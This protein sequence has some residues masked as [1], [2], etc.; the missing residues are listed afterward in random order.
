MKAKQ[1][2]EQ[3]IEQLDSV[4]NAAYA[5]AYRSKGKEAQDIG[6]L[7][8]NVQRLAKAAVKSLDFDAIAEDPAYWVRW[9]AGPIAGWRTLIEIGAELIAGKSSAE[10]RAKLMQQLTRNDFSEHCSCAYTRA[11]GQFERET[12]ATI[13]NNH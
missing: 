3:L 6:T 12:I 9:H 7:A 13:L 1:Q 2:L 8:F 11:T 10:I 5:E 4:A